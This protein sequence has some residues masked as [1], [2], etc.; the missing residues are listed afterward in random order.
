MKI[1]FFHSHLSA[2]TT[3]ILALA[4]AHGY[5]ADKDTSGLREIRGAKVPFITYEAETQQTNAAVTQL[6]YAKAV[7]ASILE[8]EASGHGFVEL[9]NTGDYVEFRNDTA[10]D[11]LTIRHCIPDSPS[12]GGVTATLGLYV[13][14]QRRQTLIL[15]SKYNWLYHADAFGKE[16]ADTNIPTPYAHTFW[17]ESR[18]KIEG[19]INAGDV[20]RLQKDAQDTAAYYRID[21]ID[22]EVIP[23][24]L[25]RPDNS[26]SAADYGAR[27]EDA[28]VDT[29]AIQKCI[30]D[31]AVQNK[32]VWLPSGN[33][34]QNEAW[35]LNGVRV[36]GAGMWYSCLYDTVGNDAPTWSANCGFR[37]NGDGSSVSDLFI[38]SLATV[39]RTRK[40]PK[41]FL[42]QGKN[43]VIRNIWIVHTNTG[44]WMGGENGVVSGCRIRSTYADGININGGG[45]HDILVENNH[46]RGTGD[47][48]LAI[49]SEVRDA[50]PTAR[51]TMR[52]NTVEA[53]RWGCACDL[54]GGGGHII[55]N[56]ILADSPVGFAINLP[57]SYPMRPMTDAIFRNN[58]ISRCGTNFNRQRRGA[59]W[60]YPGVAAIS[61]MVIENNL[62]DSP[63]FRGIHLAGTKS[64]D[65]IF[66]ENIINAPGEDAIM[67]DASVTG[68]GEFIGN[69]INQLPTGRQMLVNKA[70]DQFRLMV[71]GNSQ[72]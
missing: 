62:I 49:L 35:K 59:I 61:G 7:S 63:L 50:Q 17:D 10:A 42:G 8:S 44:L 39:R 72:K 1:C 51:I 20:I 69:K 41:P 36:Q 70:G 18:V 27:G 65:I 2:V 38:D 19:R 68:S 28:A 5:A 46:V 11:G 3:C 71:D 37:M 29:A 40:G 43:W 34:L 67:I 12:G 47:D 13:N 54:A 31:A 52:R 16:A 21:L 30:D 55:E 45:V 53:V 24:P 6:T 57:A 64:Q 56:N 22:A 66:K 23:A 25:P 33:Y 15:S 58:T 14:G 48:G 60:S 32:I 4:A 26:L 9:S